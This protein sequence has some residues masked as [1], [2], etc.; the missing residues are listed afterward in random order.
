MIS[1]L[2]TGIGLGLS[3]Y[4]FVRNIAVQRCRREIR[5]LVMIACVMDVY[6]N[7]D[8]GWRL[9]EYDKVS[10]YRMVFQFWRTFDSFYPNKDDFTNHKDYREADHD[11]PQV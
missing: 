10:Y 8:Y 7:R 6:K 9:A 4:L 2:M 3:I 5:D 11:L 1:A